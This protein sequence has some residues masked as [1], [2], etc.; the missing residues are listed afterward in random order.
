MSTGRSPFVLQT[1]MRMDIK[2]SRCRHSHGAGGQIKFEKNDFCLIMGML[3]YNLQLTVT[4]LKRNSV[5]GFRMTDC[6]NL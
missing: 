2:S 6:L 1:L 3:S 5:L 4:V